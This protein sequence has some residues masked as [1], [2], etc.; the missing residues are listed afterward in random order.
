M[1]KRQ[2]DDF[3]LAPQ[4]A[5]ARVGFEHVHCNY[6][7]P[8]SPLRHWLVVKWSCIH[9]PQI[10]GLFGGIGHGGGF[11][12]PRRVLLCYPICEVTEKTLTLTLFQLLLF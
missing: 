12:G 2:L 1:Q 6:I 4:R 5:L 9:N 7:P 11:F 8:V 3:E 10:G